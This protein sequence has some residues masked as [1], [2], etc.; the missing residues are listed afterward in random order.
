MGIFI[1]STEMVGFP[2]DSNSKEFA[3]NTGDPSSIPRWGRSPGE[4]NGNPL[5]YCLEIP[6]NRRAWLAVVYTVAK[7]WTPLSDFTLVT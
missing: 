1:F 4:R 6:M 5:Q 3:R 2:G 7:S